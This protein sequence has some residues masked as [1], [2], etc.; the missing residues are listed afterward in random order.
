MRAYV[1]HVCMCD[2]CLGNWT[3]IQRWMIFGSKSFWWKMA[4]F[5]TVKAIKWKKIQKWIWIFFF[6][7]QWESRA[8]IALEIKF[9]FFPTRH[10]IT[11][12]RHT[13][14]KQVICTNRKKRLNGMKKIVIEMVTHSMFNSDFIS[15]YI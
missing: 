11:N 2:V 14:S 1:H 8:L 4:S 13:V 9:H 12:C 3:S 7:C 10:I 15:H 6:T 5:P